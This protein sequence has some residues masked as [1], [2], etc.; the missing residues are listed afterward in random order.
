MTSMAGPGPALGAAWSASRLRWPAFADAT[1][2]WCPCRRLRQGR[3]AAAACCRRPKFVTCVDL[4]VDTVGLRF[5]RQKLWRPCRRT[6]CTNCWSNDCACEQ[7]GSAQVF[8]LRPP[9]RWRSPLLRAMA[10][11]LGF[12]AGEIE[13][14]LF[15]GV[16]GIEH[17]H[18]RWALAAGDFDLAR[19]LLGRPYA[20]GG[21][22]RPRP[23]ARTPLGF[24]TANLRFGGKT[25]HCRH[26]RGRWVHRDCR[27]MPSVSSILAR[28]PTVD[29]VE[30][31][32]ERTCSI[33]TAT[34]RAPDRS[35]EF[36]AKLR[37]EERFPTSRGG[38]DADRRAT[39]AREINK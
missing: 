3:R 14:V 28:A 16:N 21:H 8:P 24:P 11:R 15:G 9:P 23:P 36:V 1:V 25:R 2:R 17:A 10:P 35:Q 37:D 33:S 13:P 32:L 12:A 31:L 39:R 5:R 7:C 38:T 18:P 22:S 6:S 20:I 29:G 4:G 27:P 26:L 30:P 34:M 19:R